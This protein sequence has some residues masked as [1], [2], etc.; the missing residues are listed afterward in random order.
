[1]AA[2]QLGGQPSI[3][4]K[5]DYFGGVVGLEM[6][7]PLGDRMAPAAVGGKWGLVDPRGNFL[8]EPRFEELGDS[9]EGLIPARSGSMWGYVDA[10]GDWKIE[11]QFLR[12]KKFKEGWAEVSAANGKDGWVNPEG[13]FA[14]RK[15]ARVGDLATAAG[16]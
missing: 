6:A 5:T 2:V 3:V 1:M 7:P 16:H 15:P 4:D 14:V 13:K 11:P 10:K 12:A 8:F 9:S